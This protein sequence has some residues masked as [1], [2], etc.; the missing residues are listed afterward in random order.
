MIEL[1]MLGKI[2]IQ[3]YAKHNILSYRFYTWFYPQ[4]SSVDFHL[5]YAT[6]LGF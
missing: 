2:I 6:S 1:K 5:A 3:I 4:P